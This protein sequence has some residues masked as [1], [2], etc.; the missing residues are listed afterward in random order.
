VLK[1]SSLVKKLI[2]ICGMIALLSPPFIASAGQEILPNGIQRIGAAATYKDHYTPLDYSAVGVAIID[3]GIALDIPDLNVAGGVDC[4]TATGGYLAERSVVPGAQRSV[5]EPDPDAIKRETA[6]AAKTAVG[7]SSAYIAPS[8]PAL[9]DSGAPEI[10]PDGIFSL[11]GMEFAIET[12]GTMP[13][14]APAN[15][16]GYDDGNGHGTH[17]SGIVAAKQDGQGLVGVAPNARLYAVRVLGADGGGSLDNVVC[18]L[19]WVA[20]NAKD[21]GISVVNMSLGMNTGQKIMELIEPCDNDEDNLPGF[22]VKSGLMKDEFHEAVCDVV[23]AGV[24]VVVA[25][26]NGWG[27]SATTIP[28]AYPEVITVSNFADFDGA[29]GGL[30]PDDASACPQ[31]GGNDDQL[32]SHLNGS[33]TFGY[34]SY[35]GEAVDLSAPGTCVLSTFPGGMQSLT[36][37]SMASPH[38]AGTAARLV[39]DNRAQSV[40]GIRSMLLATAEDQT[41]AFRDNDEWHEPIAHVAGLT[42]DTPAPPTENVH[43]AA[44]LDHFAWG[45]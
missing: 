20:A 6:A 27:D 30:A 34:G 17:V 12:V 35:G 28:A 42:E 32:W 15:A 43:L 7:S 10:G 45:K 41:E 36:G 37:T 24:L 44:I 9:D 19:D 31:Y 22:V 11:Y 3:T 8:G 23:D 4:T 21:E 38:V 2:A 26:G 5:W 25:A 33:P 1:E 16:D 39:G 18:G 40:A 13:K 14:G 29:P